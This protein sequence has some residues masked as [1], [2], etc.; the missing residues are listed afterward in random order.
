MEQDQKDRFK[1]AD[2]V[3]V[4]SLEFISRDEQQDA[5]AR[6]TGKRVTNPP[7]FLNSCAS[8]HACVTG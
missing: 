7:L 4:R 5:A 2:L 8:Q 6:K 1:D 3:W